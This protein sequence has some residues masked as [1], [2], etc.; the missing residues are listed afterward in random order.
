MTITKNWCKSKLRNYKISY[1]LYIHCSNNASMPSKQYTTQELK[2][3]ASAYCAR[4]E[5]CISEVYTKLRQWNCNNN[6]CQQIIEDLLDN[7]FINEQRYAETYVKEK[8][9]FNRW[10]RRKI[11]QALA[12][13][14]VDKKAVQQALELIDEKEYEE[15]L[16]RLLEKKEKNIEYSNEYEKKTKLFRFAQSRG[17]ETRVIEKY[18]N[19]F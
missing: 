16:K 11:A 4:S 8:F 9:K 18:L 7:D 1:Y 13:K 10:G 19:I 14:R 15:T 12:Q 6:D 2:Q 3:K 17:F 5:H